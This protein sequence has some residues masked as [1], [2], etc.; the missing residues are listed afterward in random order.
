MYNYKTLRKIRVDDVLAYCQNYLGTNA[1]N[2]IAEFLTEGFQDK[3]PTP[4]QISQ[5]LDLHPDVVMA[6]LL[7]MVAD[8][9]LVF[10]LS[11]NPKL[12]YN[13]LHEYFVNDIEVDYKSFIKR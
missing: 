9:I 8:G 2:I 11:P 13:Y 6:E 7:A 12:S 4:T 3:T 1:R 5:E 10:Y